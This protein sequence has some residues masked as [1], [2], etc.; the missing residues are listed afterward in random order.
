MAGLV[1]GYG[2]AAALSRV[3]SD[4]LDPRT[5]LEHGAAAVLYLWTGLALSGPIV[6]VL[7]RRA[8]ATPGP[9]PTTDSPSRYT[10]DEAAWLAIG[11]YLLVL[12]TFAA[13]TLE[14]HIHPQAFRPQ[15]LTLGVVLVFVWLTL[16][17]PKAPDTAEPL[18][19]TVRAA[20][21]VV[22][23]WPLAW[24]VLILLVS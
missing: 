4:A 20:R 14:F 17:R 12:L 22:L 5:L 3:L 11:A 8:P 16:V 24:G 21:L 13:T 10:R 18:R 1:V 19:W 23:T 2:L 9:V 15:I 6:L 7:Q